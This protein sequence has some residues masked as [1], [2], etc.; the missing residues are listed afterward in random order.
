MITVGYP[1]MPDKNRWKNTYNYIHALFFFG[2]AAADWVVEEA[3]NECFPKTKVPMPG[4][5]NF[6]DGVKS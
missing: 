4:P 5:E 2:E 3:I 1:V 6:D